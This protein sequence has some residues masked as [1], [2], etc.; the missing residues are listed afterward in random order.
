MNTSIGS[1]LKS[2][3]KQ[4]GFTQEQ[5]AEQLYISQS[6]YARIETGRSNSWA[7]H[8]PKITALFNI[9]PED[10]F[11]D[12]HEISKDG[13]DPPADSKNIVPISEIKKNQYEEEI[14]K[15]KQIIDYLVKAKP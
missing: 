3:R 9:K 4:K 15:L 11:T 2:F 13:N 1:R 10:L 7:I 8:L 5:A 6:T 14:E 12:E